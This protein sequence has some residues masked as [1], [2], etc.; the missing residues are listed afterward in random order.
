MSLAAVKLGEPI[1]SSDLLASLIVDLSSRDI[2]A[3]QE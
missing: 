1:K 3:F 2:Y